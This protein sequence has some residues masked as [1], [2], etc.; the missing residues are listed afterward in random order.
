MVSPSGGLDG[1]GGDVSGVL[2]GCQEACECLIAKFNNE[3]A[4]LVAQLP[5][6]GAIYGADACVISMTI[7]LSRL[8]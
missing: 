3:V 4:Y 6:H 7:R 1:V 8:V 5:G 2:Y